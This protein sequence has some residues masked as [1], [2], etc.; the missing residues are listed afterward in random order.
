M[1]AKYQSYNGCCGDPHHRCYSKISISN[2]KIRPR[3]TRSVDCPSSR[4]DKST[5][6]SYPYYDLISIHIRGYFQHDILYALYDF[7]HTL[8]YLKPS[9]LHNH[10]FNTSN[11]TSDHAIYLSY[12]SYP[13]IACHGL[14][15]CNESDEGVSLEV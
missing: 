4:R 10:V 9:V 3:L 6:L 2:P 14:H 8:M 13:A 12:V 15:D 1:V 5:E 11:A 7:I